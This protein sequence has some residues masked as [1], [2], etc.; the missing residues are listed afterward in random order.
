M[1]SIE[2]LSRQ[3]ALLAGVLT[4]FEQVIDALQRHDEL[5]AEAF[6]HLLAFFEERVDGQHQE[7]E[8]RLFL[9]RVLTR[10]R[11]A[12]V[13]RVSSL[14]DQ[15]LVQR[16]LLVQ[17]R[18]ELQAA[19]RGGPAARARLAELGFHYLQRQRLHAAWEDEVLLPLARRVL[20]PRDDR[21][22]L[23]GYGRMEQVWGGA[24]ESAARRL[25]ARLDRPAPLILA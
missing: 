18:A 10:A 17:L 12:D 20:S 19:E 14:S 11:G 13:Q 6:E 4:R 2:I 24:F 21:A 16:Q 3:H 9:P 8:E 23:N 15:H 7:L 22:L 25:L 1:K 5:D